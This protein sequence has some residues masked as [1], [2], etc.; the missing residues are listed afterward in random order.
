[1]QL[2]VRDVADAAGMPPSAVYRWLKHDGL[3]GD[4]VLDEDRFNRLEVLDW[5]LRKAIPLRG[6][7]FQDADEMEPG[8]T[9]FSDAL[10]AGGTFHLPGGLSGPGTVAALTEVLP[11]LGAAQRLHALEAIGRG[12]LSGWTGLPDLPLAVPLAT[13][14]L[15][16]GVDRPI[17]R[18]LYP[19]APGAD[20]PAA[21]SRVPVLA[22]VWI[23][24]P[25][26]SDHL[27]MLERLAK[28]LLGER[29]IDPLVAQWPAAE[30]VPEA[31]RREAA[32]AAPSQAAGDEEP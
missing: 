29:M 1:M 32:F 17:V 15:V 10:E 31:R 7:L 16:C 30:L 8:D 22:W 9:P 4:R 20:F 21:I 12:R 3:P 2:S 28:L 19:A 27:L 23:L 13:R 26:P 25:T 11:E 14:P 18:V 5:S 6:L 24:S